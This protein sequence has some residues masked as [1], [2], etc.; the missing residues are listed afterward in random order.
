MIG[1]AKVTLSEAN[2]DEI[3]S[4]WPRR[5]FERPANVKPLWFVAVETKL[6]PYVVDSTVG[7]PE[8]GRL[9]GL[10]ESRG[11]PIPL[12]SRTLERWERDVAPLGRV[13]H[14]TGVLKLAPTDTRETE[15]EE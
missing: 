5:A 10:L 2:A 4:G 13:T 8:M 1:Y 14:R 6:G 7:R 3:I 11:G 15:N 9:I 12:T